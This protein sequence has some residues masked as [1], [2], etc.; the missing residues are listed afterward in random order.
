MMINQVQ[1]LDCVI[2]IDGAASPAVEPRI[3]NAVGDTTDGRYHRPTMCE[4]TSLLIEKTSVVKDVF[5][6][7]AWKH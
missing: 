3:A 1:C 7:T 2:V 4:G 5:N 6:L